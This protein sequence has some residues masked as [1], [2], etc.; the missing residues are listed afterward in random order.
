MTR[1]REALAARPN[2]GQRSVKE[3]YS[4]SPVLGG[5]GQAQALRA[6]PKLFWIPCPMPPL[7]RSI[8]LDSEKNPNKEVGL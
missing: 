2:T 1:P 8:A 5:T 4:H 6:A 3:S 7:G